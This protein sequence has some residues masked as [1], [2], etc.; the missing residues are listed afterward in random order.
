MIRATLE[1][2]GLPSRALEIAV[3]EASVVEARRRHGPRSMHCA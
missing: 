2:H 3:T 1:L